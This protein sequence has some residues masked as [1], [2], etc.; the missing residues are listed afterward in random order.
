VSLLDLLARIDRE[1]T[2]GT[3]GQGATLP[4]GLIPTIHFARLVFIEETSELL[5]ATCFDGSSTRQMGDLA[6]L[7]TSGMHEVLLHCREY[8]SYGGP[9]A[10]RIRDYLGDHDL[11]EGVPYVAVPGLSARL[12]REQ[13]ELHERVRTAL[14]GVPR[15]GASA[16]DVARG[17]REAVRA[18]PTP[19]PPSRASKARYYAEAFARAGIGASKIAAALPLALFLP[20]IE[21]QDAKAIEREEREES[22]HHFAGERARESEWAA[23]MERDESRWARQTGSPQSVLTHVVRLKPGFIRWLALRLSLGF[24]GYR[25]RYWDNQGQLAGIT[26][27]HFARWVIVPPDRL[28]FLSDYDGNWESYLG[29]FVD[30]GPLGLSAV[31]SNTHGFPRTKRLITQG[32][33]DERTFKH[34][35]RRNQIPTQA[36]YSAYPRLSVRNVLDNA[37]LAAGLAAGWRNDEEAEQW[38]SLV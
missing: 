30:D 7:A 6:D 18:A 34:W 24:V 33:R 9:I 14:D 36:H 19:E 3:T 22:L 29:E 35:V 38:L 1:W 37:A 15:E 16:L 2:A 23:T 28:L 11:G 10:Q 5:I 25:A 4:F 31:W 17:V 21:W 26:S 32:A 12:V 20:Q 8:F 27:I 13:D